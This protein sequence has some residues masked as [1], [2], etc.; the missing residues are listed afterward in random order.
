[1]S[2]ILF[3]TN[4]DRI[5]WSE[6]S[7]YAAEYGPK[8]AGCLA[9]PRT[10]VPPFALIPAKTMAKVSAGEPL[11][12][13]LGHDDLS[14][15][16]ELGP[17][18][19]VRSSV[20]GETI[21]ERGTYHS[22][23]AKTSPG[24]SP[25][26][27]L[28]A[29]ALEVV[30]S[31]R[32]KPSALVIQVY[33]D[34]AARGEFGNLHRVSK[35]RDQWEINSTDRTGSP[36]RTRLNSQRDVAASPDTPLS[37]RAGITTE[38]LFGAVAAWLNNELV[39]GRSERL[40]C[41]WVTDNRNF[42]LVQ[43]DAEDEDVHG[44]NP[45]QIRIQT[46]PA[47]PPGDG[48]YLKAAHGERL[49]T[50]DK[51]KVLD[52]LWESGASH[53]P[54]LFYVSLEKLP[55]KDDACSVEALAKDFRLLIGET[56]IVVR[57]S[58]KAGAKKEF[59]LPRSECLDADAAARWCLSEAGKV[60]AKGSELAF[61][62]HRFVASR[63]SA[64]VR[65]DPS[66][67]MVE[68]HALWGLPDALQYCPYD[69]WEVH[70]PT[71][72]ATDYPEYKSDILRSLDNGGWAHE[73]VKNEIARANS[74]STMEARD[75]SIRSAAIAERLGRPCHIMWFVGCVDGG[76]ESFNIPWY[77]TEAHSTEFNTDRATYNEIVIASEADLS[78]FEAFDGPW[79]R[80]A[81]ALRPRDLG[82]MRDN[83]FISRVGAAALK[84]G[85]PVILTG[86][87]LAH[88]YYQLRSQ[89]CVVVAS[90]QKDHSRI[91]RPATL[92]KLVRDK[93]PERIARRREHEVTRQVPV[94]LIKGFL[95]GKLLEEA[96]EV[97][98]AEP[99]GHQKREELADLYE[100]LA[101]LIKA[102]GFTLEDVAREADIKRAKA[103]G[104]DL[105]LVLMQTGILAAERSGSG[106]A[107]GQLMAEQTSDDVV[108]LP[109]SFFGFME[110]DQTRSILLEQFGLRLDVTLKSDRI[111]I[112]LE[113]S[114]EQLGLP[115]EQ[116]PP[117]I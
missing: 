67:P 66:N 18:L 47:P 29:A 10:W 110:L 75:I 42:Y 63:A 93:V 14:R 8:G 26:E 78:A 20:I 30:E 15:I 79:Q 91:R 39:R 49:Q 71:G 98:E 2:G 3:S 6:T 95:L 44:I 92:G 23:R 48:T 52:E 35:T 11:S 80:K 55:Q 72:T 101:A 53:K 90:G 37:V 73:R 58:V 81:L 46:A 112:R 76:G 12:H 105:G 89:G 87:T 45:L 97:R 40:N 108:E 51:L 84:A 57:T 28:D 56:G 17:E 117:L 104:F 59:N 116:P 22:E 31:S 82:L 111:E 61:V 77:W 38:R 69:I 88:A 74:I 83:D 114:S 107:L 19:I 86:S 106:E 102:E 50:W 54:T 32:G 1:M 94:S 5:D 96:I 65:V 64:W 85:L 113:R 43:I 100:V 16:L 68:V 70:L 34:A 41:E 4:V 21:W 9:L 27:A 109:F 60:S 7:I 36:S 33:V 25:V 24:L 13:V 99:G 62:A 115:L 103:G